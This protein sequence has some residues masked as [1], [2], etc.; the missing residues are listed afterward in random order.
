LIRS[1]Q[2]NSRIDYATQ[3]ILRSSYDSHFTMCDSEDTNYRG[4]AWPFVPILSSAQRIA[5][6][7]PKP[8]DYS[9]IPGHTQ[10]LPVFV[11]SISTN[12]TKDVAKERADSWLVF[13]PAVLEM[14][15]EIR[16]FQLIKRLSHFAT[17]AE[18]KHAAGLPGICQ[19]R[20]IDSPR[21][22]RV[23]KVNDR[24]TCFPLGNE[25]P[26]GTSGLTRP[27]LN[28]PNVHLRLTCR[29]RTAS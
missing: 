7:I 10:D 9:R 2:P 8:T 21:S 16:G 29:L 6:R 5:V 26:W 1:E 3:F 22:E 14:K 23:M 17:R 4:I 24:L 15:W 11:K 19:C 20:R 12:R 18:Q 13:Q 27:S 28:S 25:P